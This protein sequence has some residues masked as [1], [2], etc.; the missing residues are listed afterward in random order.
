MDPPYQGVCDTR[1]HRYVE[2][3]GFAD[4][5]KALEKLNRKGVPFLVSYDGRTGSKVHGQ[6]LPEH[7]GLVRKE[8][9]VGRSTQA[10]LLGREDQTYE[11]LYLSPA[12]VEKLGG[13]PHGLEHKRRERMPFA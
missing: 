5:S 8:I 11:S 9:L 2:A 4:F 13:V 10:T 7:L 12:L 6:E 1:D 3:V